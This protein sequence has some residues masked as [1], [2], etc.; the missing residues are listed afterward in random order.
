MSEFRFYFCVTVLHHHIMFILVCSFK[1]YT[2]EKL[3]FYYS[4]NMSSK[5]IFG[6]KLGEFTTGWEI[7]K[8]LLLQQIQNICRPEAK[9]LRKRFWKTWSIVLCTIS[10][11]KYSCLVLSCNIFI[12]KCAHDWTNEKCCNLIWIWKTDWFPA[13]EQALYI[14]NKIDLVDTF[15]LVYKSF[16]Q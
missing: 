9:G 6:N 4:R 1:K 16:L 5:L 10:V 13:S 8:G 14:N 7:I 15:H 3:I 2:L 12:I 11:F